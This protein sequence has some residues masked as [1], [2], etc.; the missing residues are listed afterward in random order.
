MKSSQQLIKPKIFCCASPRQR[1]VALIV[2]LVLTAFFGLF[3]LMGHYKISPWPFPCGF[4]QRYN[5]PCPTCGVTTS[6]EAFAQGKI[7]ESFYI[8]PAAA[9]LCSVLAVS[10]I[11]ALFIAVSGIYFDF[12]KR[13]F[14][15]IKIKY[16]V[17]A[18]IV[19]VAIGWAVTL[20]RALAANNQG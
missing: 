4:K 5:L 16:I 15:E 18:L 7:F 13:F 14:T 17:L 1:F 19:I 12:L 11:L 8:Q 2:F 9:F 6:V 3:A 20:A 10:A